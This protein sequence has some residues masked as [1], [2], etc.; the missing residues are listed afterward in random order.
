MKTLQQAEALSKSDRAL[1][2]RIKDLILQ[3]LP[4]AQVYLYGSVARGTAG[5]ESDYDVLVLTDR[6]LDM[7]E[8]N[9][10]RDAIYD[11]ELSNEVICP[12]IFY[13][14]EEWNSSP[15][16]G[17]PFRAAVEDEAIAL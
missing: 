8:K 11:I 17:S 13:S 16:S 5:P 9:L 7:D 1:I 4:D 14:K 3:R 15:L 12:I 2:S 6:R 10:V